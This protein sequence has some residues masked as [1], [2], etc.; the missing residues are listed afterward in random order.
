MLHVALSTQAATV[1]R[2]V[3][4]AKILDLHREIAHT[5]TRTFREELH[6]IVV[7]LEGVAGELARQLSAPPDPLRTAR[8]PVPMDADGEERLSVPASIRKY[9]RTHG[10][11][12]SVIHHGVAH[13]APQEAAAAHVPGREWAKAVVC[14]ADGTPM[15]AVV[16]AHYQ[17]DLSKLRDVMGVQQLRLATEDEMA[18]LYEGCELGAMPPLGPLFDQPVLVD[19]SM[20]SNAEI[21]FNGGTHRDAIRMRYHDFA[22]L[23]HPTVASFGRLH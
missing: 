23:V 10:V 11:G 16:P 3:L 8:I 1:L 19:E 12:Y 7:T 18:R 9:L 20:A 13:T 6:D 5:D 4:D 21:A 17:V 2:A 14:I 22:A 15:L